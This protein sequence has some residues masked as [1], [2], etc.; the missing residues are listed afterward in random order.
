MSKKL[1]IFAIMKIN[2]I[3]FPWQKSSVI[4]NRSKLL[5]LA[6]RCTLVNPVIRYQLSEWMFSPKLCADQRRQTGLPPLEKSSEV[7]MNGVPFFW[8]HLP[9]WDL[10]GCLP[11]AST[12]LIATITF[13]SWPCPIRLFPVV[14][15]SIRCSGF[16]VLVE[17]GIHLLRYSL[18]WLISLSVRPRL[19]IPG[20]I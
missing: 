17:R 14:C 11:L 10:A 6:K 19:L 2:I 16:W 18:R 12:P 20:A 9:W 13:L 15:I 5:F 1:C 7:V 3:S 8:L 4:R